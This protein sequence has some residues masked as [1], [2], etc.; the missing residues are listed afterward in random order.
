MIKFK[1]NCCEELTDADVMEPLPGDGM[2]ICEFCVEAAGMKPFT[3]E[4]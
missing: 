2:L 1:C 4:V 3:N